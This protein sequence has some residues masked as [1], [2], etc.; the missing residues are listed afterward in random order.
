MS[1]RLVFVDIFY[2]QNTYKGENSMDSD[3]SSNTL[4]STKTLLSK[5]SIRLAFKDK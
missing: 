4:N 5:I 2:C 1:A 3:N